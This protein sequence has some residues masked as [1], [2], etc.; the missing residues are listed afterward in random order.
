MPNTSNAKVALEAAF[1]ALINGITT[2]FLVTDTFDILGVSFTRDSLVAKLTTR[3]A[4][5]DNTATERA[6]W[7]TAVEDERQVA[8]EVNPIRA[9][10]RGILVMKYGKDSPKLLEYGYRPNKTPQKSAAAK[11]VG[12]A[13]AKATRTARHTMGSVQKKAVKGT[14]ALDATQLEAVVAAGASPTAS[15]A[16][17]P[18][19]VGGGSAPAAAPAAAR[20]EAPGRPAAGNGS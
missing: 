15:P 7:R 19:P 18:T 16:P 14:V 9:A 5:F 3:L 17:S 10:F 20:P 4:A 11:T 1:K 8:A 13:K 6:A 2:N 12:A